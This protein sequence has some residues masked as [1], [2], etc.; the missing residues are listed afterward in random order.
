M[1]LEYFGFKSEPFSISPDPRFLFMSE[2]HREALAHLLYGMKSEGGFVLLTGDIGTGK[3]TICRCLLEQLPED[4]EVALLLNPKLTAAELLANICDELRIPYPPGTTSI[5]LLVDAINGFLLDVH[6]QGRRTVVIIDEAQNLDVDVLEQIRLLTNL[7][8]NTYKLLQIIM[9][10]QP[11]LKE[12]LERPEL[13]QLSQRITA[14]Y[15]L[16]PLSQPEVGDYIRHRMAVAGVDRPIFPPASLRRIYRLT[17]GVPRLINV[18]CGRALLGAYVKGE[19]R[20]RP[21]LLAQAAEEVLLGDAGSGGRSRYALPL[22]LLLALAL[23][24]GGAVLGAGLFRPVPP[25]V[26]EAAPAVETVAAPATDPAETPVPVAE[27]PRQSWL[28][29]LAPE[30]GKAAAL[31]ALFAAWKLDYPADETA[32]PAALARESGLSFLSL[33]GSINDLRGLDRPVLLKLTGSRGESFYGTLTALDE[34]AATLTSG[35]ENYPVPVDELVRHWFGEYELLWQPPPG[36]RRALIPGDRGVT[37]EWLARRFDLLHQRPDRPVAGRVY[38]EALYREVREFQASEGLDAD[39]L[40][41]PLTL[42][43]LNNR[44]GGL[45]PRLNATPKG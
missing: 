20:V 15:H 2:R 45:Q 24:G 17:G 37:V 26:P 25:I 18:L 19:N 5:K 23:V 33:R 6:A 36:Y 1:Y 8:T 43:R 27:P 28:E 41:G 32:D 31:H 22:K 4:S 34:E 12:M 7:E 13:R 29:A 40:V 30:A 42:I 10:G 14:R 9:L 35:A 44:T 21:A 39:G 11:E 3:T 16:A 38:D